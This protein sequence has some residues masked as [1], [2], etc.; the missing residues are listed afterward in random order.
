[1]SRS[2]STGLD[3]ALFVP[4]G[5]PPLPRCAASAPELARYVRGFGSRD[6][7]VGVLAEVGGHPVGAAWVRLLTG[8]ERGYGYVDDQ[9]PE[10]TVAVS[11]PQRGCGIGTA[12]LTALIAQVRGIS[13]SCD[14]RNPAM[15]LYSRFGF[16]AVDEHDTSATLLRVE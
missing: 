11:A 10:L 3:E 6:G 15:R 7:D 16:V 4:P 8:G 9:T 1:M 12:L 2:C 5:S 14:T 13:L